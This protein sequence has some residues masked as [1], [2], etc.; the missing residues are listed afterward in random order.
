MK[1]EEARS[2]KGV[3]E[4]QACPWLQFKSPQKKNSNHQQKYKT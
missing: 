1:G 3:G 4:E 2:L